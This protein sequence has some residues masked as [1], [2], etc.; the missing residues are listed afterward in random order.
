[1]AR[2]DPRPWP[3]VPRDLGKEDIPDQRLPRPYNIKA[4]PVGAG[5]KLYIATEQGDVVVVRM[6]ETYEVLATNTLTDQSF[7]ATPAVAGGSL[8][9]RS[10]EALYCIRQ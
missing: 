1:V 5:G 3:L 10:R 7:I 8:Y 4:S 2:A 9:L 6:G